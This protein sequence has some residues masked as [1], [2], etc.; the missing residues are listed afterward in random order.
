MA[1]QKKRLQRGVNTVSCFNALVGGKKYTKDV[2]HR[3]EVYIPARDY[4][5]V[6]KGE[7][8][9]GLNRGGKEEET[10]VKCDRCA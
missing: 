6:L 2:G 10:I 9:N 3:R 7:G 5:P 1:K 4:V 8:I